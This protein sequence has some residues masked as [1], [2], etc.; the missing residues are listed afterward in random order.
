MLRWWWTKLHAFIPG[1]RNEN[2]HL[3]SSFITVSSECSCL[4]RKLKPE[5]HFSYLPPF[6]YVRKCCRISFTG[7]KTT[8]ICSNVDVQFFLCIHQLSSFHVLAISSERQILIWIWGVRSEGIQREIRG[9]GWQNGSRHQRQVQC[10]NNALSLQAV[11]MP[12][13]DWEGEAVIHS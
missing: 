9:S 3:I 1:V 10:C 5:T 13:I 11:V 12:E 4:K 6:K 2:S 8:I 7:A